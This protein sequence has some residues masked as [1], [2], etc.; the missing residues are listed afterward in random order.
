MD[1]FC[2]QS[3]TG[4]LSLPYSSTYSNKSSDISDCC[5][6]DEHQ[7]HV[8]GDVLR[9]TLS[10]RQEQQQQ[11]QQTRRS[12]SKMLPL[13]FFKTNRDQ[14]N[15]PN[16]IEETSPWK[17]DDDDEKSL[18][19]YVGTTSLNEESTSGSEYVYHFFWGSTLLSYCVS[20]WTSCWWS[21]FLTPDSR[22]RAEGQLHDDYDDANFDTNVVPKPNNDTIDKASSFRWNWD[23]IVTVLSILLGLEILLVFGLLVAWMGQTA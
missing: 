5:S 7:I 23:L 3:S 1:S 6:V 20:C 2:N 22:S 12:R 8:F 15:S 11:Q 16:A 10:N 17:Y 18:A 4:E 21:W 9:Q 19:T 14:D 13:F